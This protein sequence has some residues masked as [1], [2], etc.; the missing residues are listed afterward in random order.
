MRNAAPSEVHYSAH[1]SLSQF[2]RFTAKGILL[3]VKAVPTRFPWRVLPEDPSR[4]IPA[5]AFPEMRFPDPGA[6]PPAPPG[7]A[8]PG[9]V[10]TAPG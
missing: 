8:P 5:K 4:A 10:P 6:V 7:N 3:P 9:A 2:F 1:V